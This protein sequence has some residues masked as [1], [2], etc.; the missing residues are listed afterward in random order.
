[1]R[2]RDSS[3]RAPSSASRFTAALTAPSCA[4]SSDTLT[5]PSDSASTIARCIVAPL[6]G[7][8]AEPATASAQRS[9]TSPVTAARSRYERASAPVPTSAEAAS[10]AERDERRNSVAVIS[11]ASR[12]AS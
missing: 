8:K 6:A 1:M 9:S 11:P 3:R 5:G 10:G 12:T 7:T 2:R 4:P